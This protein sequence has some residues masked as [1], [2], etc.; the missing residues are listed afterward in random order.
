[1]AVQGGPALPVSVLTSPVQHEGGPAIPVAVVTDGRAT[2]GG[3]AQPIIVVTNP[4]RILGG[5][6]IP[7]VAAPAGARVAGESALRV[8]V[9]SGGFY[10]HTYYVR[11]T[12]NDTTGN[13][14][15][16][17]PW[18]T[19]SKAMT[20]AV[21]QDLVLVGDGTY[22][23]NTS[24]SGAW[25]ITK[26][27]ASYLTIQSESGIAANVII[28]GTSSSSNTITSGTN[29]FLRFN[30]LTFGLRATS[31]YAFR[32]NSAI[33]NFE[34][35]GCIFDTNT[36]GA[37]GVA[38]VAHLSATAVV[39]GFVC[40]NCTFTASPNGSFAGTLDIQPTSTGSFT[41]TFT[42]CTFAAKL[43]MVGSS[44]SIVVTISGGSMA[45]TSGNGLN[46]NGANI[47]LSTI[48]ITHTAAAT[49][50]Q[51]GVDGTSGN[52]TIGSITGCTIQRST[53]LAGHALLIGAG[54]SGFV[55]N[56]VVVPQS[57]DYACVIKEC[58]GAEVKNC[59]L[60]GGATVAANGALYCKA[61][62]GVNAHDNALTTG[63]NFGVR[64]LKG[65][66]GNKSGTITLQN[67]AITTIGSA[68]ALDWGDSTNDSGGGVCDFN[69]YNIHTS[70][71]IGNVRAASGIT[72]L[73]GLIAA[74]S[75]Y[76]VAGNDTHSTVIP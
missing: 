47:T 17:A 74:W 3:P 44:T 4:S 8:Y 53:S 15:S 26:N 6:A 10:L 46:V 43:L 56:S 58:A 37:S 21:A 62:T 12:G 76:D 50:V 34:F 35:N 1:M 72:T 59:T 27:L 41:G 66:T 60:T 33:S 28:T 67:N 70:G 39:S 45:I 19:L 30:N 73:A 2:V 49:S 25:Q 7:I 54:C 71:V 22:A 69:T 42:G 61:A 14:S 36:N 48:A 65:D 31:F 63:A 18:L 52:T 29:A 5:P 24:A 32:I 55:V 20:I 75:G 51:L 57:Y 23:E 16:A 9:V 11:K 40:N 13:G 68:V 64:V 38:G